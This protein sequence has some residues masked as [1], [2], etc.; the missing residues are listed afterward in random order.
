MG[1]RTS[2]MKRTPGTISALP[3]SRHSATLVIDLLAHFALDLSGVAGEE[4][5]EALLPRVDDVDLVERDDVHHLLALL[6]L[7]LGALHEFGVGAHGVVVARAGERAAKDGDAAGRLVNSNHVARLAL[8]LRQAVNHLLAEVVHLSGS[9]AV[10]CARV[11]EWEGH[12]RGVV[13]VRMMDAHARLHLGRLQR[14]AHVLP[15]PAA[16]PAAGRSISISTT[17]PSIISVSS[18]IRTPIERRKACVSASAKRERREERAAR[19]R[20]W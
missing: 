2:S 9:K 17:S 16:A 4:G 5:E 20:E 6:Q 1:V 18:L 19:A 13:R 7:A 3:S 15:A 11:R 8:L 12:W 14:E 10:V